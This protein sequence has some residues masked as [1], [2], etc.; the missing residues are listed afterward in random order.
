[1]NPDLAHQGLLIFPDGCGLGSLA[2]TLPLFSTI[3]MAATSQIVHL[4]PH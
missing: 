2:G 1:V 4:M 3:L